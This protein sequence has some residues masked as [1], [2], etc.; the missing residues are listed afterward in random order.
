MPSPWLKFGAFLSITES[1]LTIK[2]SKRNVISNFKMIFSI[3]SPQTMKCGVVAVIN[4]PSCLIFKEKWEAAVSDN[5]LICERLEVIDADNLPG[6]K[7]II[8][9]YEVVLIIGLCQFKEATRIQLEKLTVLL[10]NI[11]LSGAKR[12]KVSD[13][14]SF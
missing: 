6:F 2:R 7:S 10:A 3:G 8:E 4:D 12:P 5:D 13:L 14:F 11:P 1:K 9:S